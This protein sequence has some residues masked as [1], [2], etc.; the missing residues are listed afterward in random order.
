MFLQKNSGTPIFIAFPATKL[1]TGVRFHRLD[2]GFSKKATLKKTLLPEGSGCFHPNTPIM[3][4]P[5]K[6]IDPGGCSELLESPDFQEVP[7]G[8][9]GSSPT[10]KPYSIP[11][12]PRWFPR[13]PRKFPRLPW[14]SPRLSRRSAPACWLTKTFSQISSLRWTWEVLNGVGVDGVGVIFPFFYAFFPF[15]Y[16]IFPFFYAFFPFFYAFLCFS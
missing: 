12:V 8:F 7:G 2:A 11:E 14:K 16:A 5:E 15:F 6:Y 1:K 9:P 4:N 10:V 13:L 3:R